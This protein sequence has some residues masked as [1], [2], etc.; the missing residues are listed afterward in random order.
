MDWDLVLTR[1]RRRHTIPAV[2]PAEDPMRCPGCGFVSFDHLPTCKRCG[3]ALPGREKRQGTVAIQMVPAPAALRSAGE[4]EREVG[5]QAGAAISELVRQEDAASPREGRAAETLSG[6]PEVQDGLPIAAEGEAPRSEPASLPKAGFW[7]RSVAFLVDL[8]T[9]AVL[10][11]V[12]SFL[13]WGAVEI[14]GA[15]SS[16]SVFAL[17]W[18]RMT[19]TTVL[20]I[21]IVLCYFVLLVGWRGQTPGKILLGLKII[22]ITGEEVGRGRAFVRWMGQILGFLTFGLGFLMVAFSRRKQGLHDK[23]AGTCVVRLR[24]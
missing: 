5:L 23:L 17:D 16:T 7:V 6:H 1:H 12:G 8:A 4:G 18:L 15:F 19:A 21:L 9:A 2:A 10:A 3:R 20:S 24:S 14:G 11:F 13:V 22:R